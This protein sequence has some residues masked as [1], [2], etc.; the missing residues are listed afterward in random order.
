MDQPLPII[1]PDPREL[2]SPPGEVFRRQ[3]RAHT[4][5]EASEF[6]DSERRAEIGR[7]II[8]LG[9][10]AL[11]ALHK[12]A[13]SRHENSAALARNLIKLLVPDEIGKQIYMGLLREKRDYAVE[14][15]ATLLARLP[16]PNLPVKRVLRDIETLAEK[17][18]ERVYA[19]L[20]IAPDEGKKVAVERAID[21][22]KKLGEF[23]RDEGFHGSSE[24]YHGE[25]NSY[26]PDVLERRTGLP[27]S[28]SVLY[29]AFA[30]RLH[31]HAE[32]VGMP[33]HFIVR[34]KVVTKEG[35][36]YILIDPF[37]G[38]RPM[39]IEDCRQRVESTGQPFVPE[40]HLKA[41]P[42]R[43][44]LARMCNNLLALFDHQ[45]KPLDAERVATIL[46]HIQPRDPVPLLIRAERRLRRGER[47]GAR[48]D[49]EQA[50]KLD[51]AGPV[52]RTADELL[53][54]MEYEHP[55]R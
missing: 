14:H 25:R 23:W 53:R 50:R 24:S 12:A 21:L 52:G 33:G 29:L 27:I 6:V 45:K 32:G 38:G 11:P 7:E 51:P 44:I 49:F 8:M 3:V 54:R 48:A 31:L 13:A 55:F 40:D 30:R 18:R 28:L 26:L 39:D 43:D 19:Q 5:L 47:R 1:P 46:I 35:D 9:A 20:D 37:N 4:L 34:V 17:C 42:A 2:S 16:N 10:D 15:G 36:Q 41:T 22:I